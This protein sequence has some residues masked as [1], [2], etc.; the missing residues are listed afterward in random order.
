MLFCESTLAMGMP[1]TCGTAWHGSQAGLAQDPDQVVIATPTLAWHQ[2]LPQLASIH[3]FC[4]PIPHLSSI[5]QPLTSISW[6]LTSFATPHFCWSGLMQL[7][8]SK[9][10][11]YSEVKPSPRRGRFP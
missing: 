3:D 6:P 2:V 9:N 7:W 11:N 10:K 1:D 4:R 8:N 5:G